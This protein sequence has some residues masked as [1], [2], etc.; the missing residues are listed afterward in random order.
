[1]DAG[2]G[3]TDDGDSG[4]DIDNDGNM[5]VVTF[6]DVHCSDSDTDGDVTYMVGTL[7]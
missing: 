2:G 1:M 3:D 4:S 6:S 7:V 5:T